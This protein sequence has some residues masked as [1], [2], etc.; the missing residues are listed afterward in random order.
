MELR[1]LMEQKWRKRVDKVLWG[2]EGNDGT[3]CNRIACT[4]VLEWINNRC[5]WEEFEEFE[6][7]R[8]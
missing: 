5:R 8:R 2:G 6:E 3:L 4:K 7:L 1:K